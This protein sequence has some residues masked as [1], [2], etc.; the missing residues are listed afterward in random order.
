PVTAVESAFG[1]LESGISGYPQPSVYA[2]ERNYE[3]LVLASEHYLEKIS[4]NTSLKAKNPNAYAK[5]TGI[6][7]NYL[8]FGK[9]MTRGMTESEFFSG[10]SLRELCEIAILISE[11]K[12]ACRD[13]R[14]LIDLCPPKQKVCLRC[15]QEL[16]QGNPRNLF[17]V[18]QDNAAGYGETHS[19]TSSRIAALLC[20]FVD[21]GVKT[22]KPIRG[23]N[24]QLAEENKQLGRKANWG[25]V[26]EEEKPEFSLQLVNKAPIIFRDLT[27][28][29][30]ELVEGFSLGDFRSDIDGYLAEDGIRAAEKAGLPSDA[31]QGGFSESNPADGS[32]EFSEG[33]SSGTAVNP[34]SAPE[35]VVYIMPEFVLREIRD[36]RDSLSEKEGS[37]ASEKNGN[38]SET[39]SGKPDRL[40]ALCE[41]IEKNEDRPEDPR[42][43][44]DWAELGL[45]LFDRLRLD[46]RPDLVKDEACDL[47]KAMAAFVTPDMLELLPGDMLRMAIHSVLLSADSLEE[48]VQRCQTWMSNLCECIFETD[49][50]KCYRKHVK[51]VRNVGIRLSGLK[52]TEE[53]V[54]YLEKTIDLCGKDKNPI[55]R[56][57]KQSLLNM[58]ND[59]LRR[60]RNRGRLT[61]KVYTAEITGSDCP[62]SGMVQ[63][64]GE[65]AATDVRLEFRVNDVSVSDVSIPS[66]DGGVDVPFEFFIPEEVLNGGK[67]NNQEQGDKQ[68]RKDKEIRYALVL[69]YFA[70]EEEE[71]GYAGQV[72]RSE[73]R[74]VKPNYSFFQVQRPDLSEYT[75]RVAIQS[76]LEALYPQG[77]NV[78]MLPSLAV[79]GMRRMGKSWL[80]NWIQD[81]LEKTYGNAVLVVKTSLEGASAG[82]PTLTD[83]AHFCLVKKVLEDLDLRVSDRDGEAWKEF[84]NKWLDAPEDSVRFEWIPNFFRELNH[85]FLNGAGIHL[86]LILDEVERLYL[87]FNENEP[88]DGTDGNP[89]VREDGF[90]DLTRQ[91][92][93]WDELGVA[94]QDE[95][96]GISLIL[97]GADP[98]TNTVMGGD[99]LTQF[100][101][102][103]VEKI[104]VG[105][106]TKTE[107]ETSLRML[108]G[109]SDL[110]Y[111]DDAIEYLWALTSGL[112]WHTKKIVNE[113]VWR[114]IREKERR[115]TL[116][117]SDMLDA[118]QKCAEEEDFMSARTLG[119]DAP[120]RDESV[121]LNL[122]ADRSDSA[123]SLVRRPELL[124]AFRKQTGDEDAEK[125]FDA[126]LKMLVEGRQLVLP[127]KDEQGY[128]YRFGS[129]FNRLFVRHA[130]LPGFLAKN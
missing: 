80:L 24:E 130:E 107:M 46:G 82:R 11:S 115:V 85:R 26:S 65:K 89:E 117:P 83:R 41:R 90:T 118:A 97:C 27:R 49:K 45:I 52:I 86:M 116:F 95:T 102:K 22:K 55:G 125:R 76:R 16:I 50:R 39:A 69:R 59:E 120:G 87:D 28:N 10:M 34:E 42:V 112:P 67:K 75:D 21:Q 47:L 111:E 6:M 70:D 25:I 29:P 92:N 124:E 18:L 23:L 78:A 109:R 73:R 54:D 53:R 62:L 9:L 122:L 81:Y 68:D 104:S 72:L 127:Q 110:K 113:A 19:G 58:L 48:L 43:R 14:H 61:M 5:Q 71:I 105:R 114:L 100:F 12:G 66:I 103:S 35:A 98:F 51:F 40:D 121:F 37:P 63:N 7:N 128:A 38:G 106:M 30:A 36:R 32:E 20:Q 33:M 77:G 101:Q 64:L 93:F 56:E 108:E 1:R 96:H 15:V 74:E 57:L 13:L 44:A 17:Y 79:Y 2:D 126:V 119:M 4:S 84:R 91:T 99:N 88:A 60:Y 3:M 8:K 123:K 31:P 94:L 129:E